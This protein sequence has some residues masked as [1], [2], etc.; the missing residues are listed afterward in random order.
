MLKGPCK[1]HAPRAQ[2][3]P[4]SPECRPVSTLASKAEDVK[5]SRMQMEGGVF[6][7]RQESGGLED[8]DRKVDP[9]T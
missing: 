5:K 2:L 8:V 6:M 7:C 3:R 9:A 4:L 1:Q